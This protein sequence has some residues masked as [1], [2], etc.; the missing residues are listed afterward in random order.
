MARISDAC[1]CRPPLTFYALLLLCF[2]SDTGQEKALAMLDSVR[3]GKL[4]R[5]IHYQ[6]DA[7]IADL[8]PWVGKPP[9]R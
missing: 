4:D 2:H 6:I 7:Q 1:V 3:G 5:N 8:N 9:A